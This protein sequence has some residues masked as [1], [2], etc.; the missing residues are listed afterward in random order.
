VHD[1]VNILVML[2]ETEKGSTVVDVNR[3]VN[4]ECALVA[5]HRIL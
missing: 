3:E 4:H 2:N 5:V 1:V